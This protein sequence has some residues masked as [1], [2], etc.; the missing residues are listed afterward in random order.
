MARSA[1]ARRRDKDVKKRAVRPASLTAHCLVFSA[2]HK[3]FER[4]IQ[5]GQLVD[6]PLNHGPDTKGGDQEA[7][8]NQTN[9]AVNGVAGNQHDNTRPG[10]QDGGCRTY[11]FGNTKD[12]VQKCDGDA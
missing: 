1:P 7:Y 5:I 11:P 4:I 8:H 2:G 3:V 12:E 9:A 6:K 10:K